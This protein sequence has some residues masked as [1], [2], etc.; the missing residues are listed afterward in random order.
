MIKKTGASLLAK[1]RCQFTVWAPFRKSVEVEFDTSDLPRVKLEKDSHG[2]WSKEIDQ[3]TPGTRYRFILDDKITRPDPSSRA[4]PDGVH[5][6]SEVEDEHNH[7]WGDSDWE[8]IALQDM[9]IYELHIGTFTTEGT[10]ESAISKLDHLVD[11]GINAIE[12]MPISQFPGNRN[13]GYDGVYPYAAQHSY[14]GS[15]GLK[16]LVDACHQ[17]GIAVILDVVYNHMGPE[18]NYLADFGPYFTD[19]HSTPWGKAINFDDAYSDHVRGYF[20]RNA[21]MWLDD[22]HIDALRLDAVHAIIDSGATHF[23]K[24]LRQNV[25]ELQIKNQRRYFLI[26]ESELNDVKIIDSYDKG[27]YGL[28]AQW[29]DDFHHAVHTLATGEEEGYYSDYGKIEHLAKA[30]RQGFVYDGIYSSFRKKTVGNNPQSIQSSRFVICIQNHD[31]IGNRMLGERLSQLVS[32]EMLKLTASTMLLSPYTPMLYMGEEYGERHP[33][34]YFISH[35]DPG[36]VEAV[37][38]GR[39]NEFKAFKWKG[40]VPD[41]QAEET[42]NQSKLKWDF[43]NDPEQKSL[44]TYYQYLI[45]LRKQGMFSAF[46]SRHLDTE[47]HEEQKLL[48]IRSKDAIPGIGILLVVFNFS[49]E[50]Q[51]VT[52]P[53][54]Y[55]RWYKICSS[56]DERWRGKGCSSKTIIQRGEEIVVAAESMVL[57]KSENS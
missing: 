40:Q 5:S 54:S 33:F 22:F 50:H 47:V 37:R 43:D 32:F 52:M 20:L 38:K 7:V 8:G 34:L 12:I 9:I 17:R 46:Y 29:A 14:G 19:R 26:A 15:K 18:G 23:L 3:I 41:P 51:H 36:L 13:W 21:L 56:S 28:D 4:Q 6:W 42:F 2:Y 11:L 53:A 45:S 24:E 49:K 16:A 48:I 10:F 39:S 25:D 44:F 31:Q 57:Y 55:E 35:G 30:F 27:G 1:D